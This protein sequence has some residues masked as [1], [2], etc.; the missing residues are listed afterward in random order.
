MRALGAQATP[1]IP[2]RFEEGYALSQAAIT[3]ACSFG[4]DFIVTVDCGI[5]CKAEAAAV[6]EA[7]LGLAITDPVSYT[8]LLHTTHVSWGVTASSGSADAGSTA[9]W[10]AGSVSGRSRLCSCSPSNGKGSQFS[11]ATVPYRVWIQVYPSLRLF[12]LS[13]TSPSNG[14][15]ICGISS[16]AVSYTHLLTYEETKQCVES[17]VFGVNTP[18]R[19][20][21]QAP[22]SNITLDWVCPADLRDQPAIV[23]CV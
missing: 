18:S 9:G 5:A 15:T 8:H 23:R 10:E 20:G 11:S 13:C 21:T 16:S 7:G 22:F 4:P 2:L 3:R 14:S 19:W 6:V 12:S 1:F 17:F